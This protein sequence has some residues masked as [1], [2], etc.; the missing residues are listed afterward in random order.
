MTAP[1]Y[2]AAVD[3]RQRDE[4]RARQA[5]LEALEAEQSDVLARRDTYMRKLRG[6]GLGATAQTRVLSAVRGEF[7][8]DPVNRVTVARVLGSSDVPVDRRGELTDEQREQLAAL[9]RR[10]E[11]LEGDGGKIEQARDAR[12][13]YFVELQSAHG[14]GPIEQAA[15]LDVHRST[16]QRVLD[17]N[18]RFE[19][20]RRQGD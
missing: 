8:R 13:A 16:V 4:L 2:G 18:R 17:E 9:Q 6:L 7:G 11:Q 14:V 12:N 1:C 3:D 10:L 5:H 20:L 19:R 15:A